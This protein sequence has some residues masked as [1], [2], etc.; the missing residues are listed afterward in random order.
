M[1]KPRTETSELLVLIPLSQ[2]SRGRLIRF[3][4]AHLYHIVNF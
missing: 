4:K 2:P 3:A 1:V